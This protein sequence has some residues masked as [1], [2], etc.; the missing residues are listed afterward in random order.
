MD[1]ADMRMKFLTSDASITGHPTKLLKI[2]PC[3]LMPELFRCPLYFRNI[4]CAVAPSR[5]GVILWKI[6]FSSQ[7]VHP[8]VAQL[9]RGFD[10]SAVFCR[11]ASAPLLPYLRWACTVHRQGFPG[12]PRLRV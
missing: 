2:E 5:V 10:S 12:A 3:F 6:T 1:L 7:G 11:R 4:S 9:P 8:L